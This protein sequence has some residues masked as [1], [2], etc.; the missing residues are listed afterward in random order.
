MKKERRI[1]N[2][3][4]ISCLRNLNTYDNCPHVGMAI[5][6]NVIVRLNGIHVKSN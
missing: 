4:G 2:Y 1:L 6:E 5:G 3:E